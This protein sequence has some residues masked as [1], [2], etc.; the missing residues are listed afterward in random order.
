MKICVNL[1]A[2][3]ALSK[4]PLDD[5]SSRLS[6]EEEERTPTATNDDSKPDQDGPRGSTL[7]GATRVHLN[8][9]RVLPPIATSNSTL[10][11]RP[12]H[13][14]CPKS[15]V[16]QGGVSRQGGV[17]NQGGLSSQGGVSR[18]GGVYNQGGLSSQG[19]VSRQGGVYNQG[20]LSSQGGV[21]RQCGV[22]SQGGLSS[23]G[24]VSRQGG[25]YNQGGLSSQG[26]VSRQGGVNNQGGVSSQGADQNETVQRCG[27]SDTSIWTHRILQSECVSN[28]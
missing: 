28:V 24:G 4:E 8:P 13:Y 23:Q 16:D 19:G 15:L 5:H 22:S 17:Y 1:M 10:G 3:L 26:G 21:S 20:G 11:R 12:I 9:G 27:P 7:K 6:A 2:A 18:Q 25:V 14:D